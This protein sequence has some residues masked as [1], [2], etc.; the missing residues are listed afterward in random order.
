LVL[1]EQVLTETP[2]ARRSIRLW[3]LIAT[4]ALLAA[5]TVLAP[6]H[7]SLWVD[8]A[9]TWNVVKDG[10]RAMP[11]RLWWNNE[12][13]PVFFAFV[14]ASAR[15]FGLSEW[16]LRLPSV[17]F[18]GAACVF[19]YRIARRWFDR[20]ISLI[21]VI[22]FLAN[23]HV[24]FAASDAR[25]YGMALC[26]VALSTLLLLRW[27]EQARA[28]DGALYAI[29]AA[30]VIYAH[31]LWTPALLAQAAFCALAYPSFKWR[32]P[33]FAWTVAALLCLPLLPAI[34]AAG[35]ARAA[36]S[37][38][39]AS[40]LSALLE[41]I[42]PIGVIGPLVIAFALN[43][44]TAG[45]NPRKASALPVFPVLAT[46]TAA[47][48]PPV[49]LYSVFLFTDVNPFV[50]R[51]YLGTSLAI[52]LL[53]AWAIGATTPPQVRNFLLGSLVAF[54]LL[55]QGVVVRSHA[56]QDWRG[57]M[58]EVRGIAAQHP[59]IPVLLVSG[60]QESNFPEYLESPLRRQ[61]VFA[62]SL[63]YPG[64]GR[65]FYL[66]WSFAPLAQQRIEAAAPA[67]EHSRQFVLVTINRAAHEPY[68]LGRFS[69]LNLRVQS[70]H[71]FES[72]SVTWYQAS[73]ER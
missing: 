3:G 22:A 13:S 66:P 26:A 70:R 55:T 59:D 14:C 56:K 11:A 16:S 69:S 29:A 25:V 44:R 71:D 8:E 10:F 43:R 19:L 32:R 18:V 6:L 35:N 45:F 39:T 58:A 63:V 36:M 12:Q 21:A 72:V 27:T 2:A 40:P 9:K 61:A 17:M 42:L 34:R 33:L 49:L 53:A 47:A 24:A 50:P 51:Y 52:A 37:F 46:F 4:L 5:L 65:E 68:L 23:P 15:I 7:S 41:A 20:E 57:A 1:A 73:S 38:A 67:V 30:W 28:L 31:L 54:S 64:G 48:I 62:A 60:F